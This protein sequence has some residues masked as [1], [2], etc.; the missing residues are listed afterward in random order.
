[1]RSGCEGTPVFWITEPFG[2]YR[3]VYRFSFCLCLLVLLSACSGKTV[4]VAPPS[5]ASTSASASELEGLASYYAEPYHGR[6]TASGEV[7][8]TYK[9][10]TAAHRTLPFNTVV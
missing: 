8:D 1:M 5:R 2:S 6:R 7:F 9:A 3:H 4:R 10:M